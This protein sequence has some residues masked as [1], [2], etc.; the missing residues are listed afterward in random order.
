MFSNWFSRLGFEKAQTFC[1]F[2]DFM[3][4]LTFVKDFTEVNIMVPPRVSK[5]IYY[6]KNKTY[7]HSILDK[8]VEE[9]NEHRQAVKKMK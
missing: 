1:K 3:R 5:S 4:Y 2:G 9:S 7:M 8:L 6:V